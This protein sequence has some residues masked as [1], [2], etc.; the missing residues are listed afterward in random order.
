MSH[1]PPDDMCHVDDDSV[2]GTTTDF[3]MSNSWISWLCQGFIIACSVICAMICVDR[4]WS[5]GR[6]IR[7]GRSD[8]DGE[9]SSNNINDELT[10]LKSHQSGAQMQSYNSA[11]ANVFPTAE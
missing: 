8:G 4:F 2:T 7:S 3:V 5:N 9:Q 6:W 1:Y 10:K 11:D